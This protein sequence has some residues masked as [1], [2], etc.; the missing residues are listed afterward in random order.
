M[1]DA[2]R[3]SFPLFAIALI[4]VGVVLLL[5]RLQVITFGFSPVFWSLVMFFGLVRVT[6]GF[7][8]DF[9]GR[10]FGGTVLFLY[11]LF[12][13]LHSSEF[14][15]IRLRMFF[16]ATF[17]ILGIALLMVYLNNVREW[18]LLIPAGLLCGIGVAFLMTEIGYLDQYEVWETVRMYWPLGLVLVGL[19]M[20]LRRR[21]RL[22]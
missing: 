13:L 14:V 21:T 3:G 4:V 19:A 11:G 2:R 12:F 8:H 20:I 1:P 9:R 22:Q 15:D 16:P 5:D 18:E 10:I 6:Q 7:S 17:L